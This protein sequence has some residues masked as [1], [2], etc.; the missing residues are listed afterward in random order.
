VVTSGAAL[1][2]EEDKGVVAVGVVVVV[3][4]SDSIENSYNPT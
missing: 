3:V 4:V 2:G 1:A